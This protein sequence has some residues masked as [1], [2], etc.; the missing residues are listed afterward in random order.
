V[1]RQT[2][3]RR[4]DAAAT[5]ALEEFASAVSESAKEIRRVGADNAPRRPG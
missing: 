4:F 5:F 3:R 2:P 1:E